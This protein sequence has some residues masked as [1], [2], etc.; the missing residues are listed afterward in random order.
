MAI[1]KKVMSQFITP[2]LDEFNIY[3]NT[4]RKEY[5]LSEN[6]MLRFEILSSDIT[7]RHKY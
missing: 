6:Y 7:F 5:L 4:Q 3:G 1:R 2:V